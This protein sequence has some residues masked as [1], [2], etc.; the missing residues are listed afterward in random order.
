MRIAIFHNRYVYRGGEDS[1]VDIEAELLRKA[2]HQVHLFTVDNREALAGSPLGAVRAGLRARWNPEIHRRVGEFVLRESI[3][4]G[5]VHNF[6]P[7][8][9]PAVHSALSERGIPVVQTLHNYRL[10]C[11]NGMFLRAERTCEDCVERGPWNAVR[12]GCYRGSR[13]QTAVWADQTATHHRLGTWRNHVDCFAVPSAFAREKLLAADLPPERVVV[14]PNSVSDPGEP[15][16]PGHGAVF[17]GR[18]AREKGV[19]LL[20]D[21]WRR[22]DGCR[23]HIAG[24]GPEEAHLRE[25]AATVPGVRFLGE[26]DRESV[27]SA[28]QAAAFTIVPSIWYE[29]FPVA[30]AEAMACGRPSV[31]A[32]PSAL[33]EFVDHGRT[34]LRFESGSVDSLA[35]AC[36]EMLRD[37]ERTAAM[38]RE[39][40]ADYEDRLTPEACTT[41]L[42]EIYARAAAVRAGRRSITAQ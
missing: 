33:D 1:V 29:N 4:V 12:H 36:A 40:R 3:D 38:G 2:G 7:L 25:Q 27:I 37:P 17:V 19:H 8:L 11:A 24:T 13:L 31:A 41:N 39:A 30:L 23:L 21:A 28:M 5:H 15:R 10:L 32:S 20:L 35:A 26:I 14:K 22:M 16:F 42:L 6:F 9:S 34:G 18:L